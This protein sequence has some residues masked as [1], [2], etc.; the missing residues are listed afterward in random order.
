MTFVGEVRSVDGIVLC[1]DS[2]RG[3]GLVAWT[4]GEGVRALLHVV[5]LRP[6]GYQSAMAGDLIRC[7]VLIRPNRTAQVYRV[8]SL[9]RCQHGAA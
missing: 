3:Y 9:V 4:G 8:N 1:F 7:Q 6:A 2:Q 5:A